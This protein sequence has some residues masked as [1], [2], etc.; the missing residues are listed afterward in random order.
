MYIEEINSTNSYLKQWMQT[1]ALP[2][3]LSHEVLPH[4]RAGYQTAGRGQQGN[5]WESERDMNLTCSML[6]RN[7]GLG[8]DE[9]WLISMMVSVAVCEVIDGYLSAK[10][11][12]QLTIKWPNDIYFG[13]YKLAGILIEHSLMG[14][15]IEYSIVGVGLNVNQKQFVS[16][17][18]PI[19]LSQ[20]T[21]KT[22][23]LQTVMD[24]M[25]AVT[26][27]KIGELRNT[28]ILR[29][30]YLSRLYRRE[31]F[32]PFVEREVSVAPTMNETKRVIDSFDAEIKTIT[33]QGQLVLLLRS[34][35]ERTYHFKQI[36]YVIE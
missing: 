15:Q 28:T 33:P 23:D 20:I 30:E 5:G 13:D 10:E 12:Q 11:R 16:A 32:H 4:I 7:T 17:P 34:G 36:R 18:N 29:Q 27:T 21:G 9:Q 2:K 6:I 3:P 31:G 35:E 22:L 8:A 25:V 1:G 14:K 26:Y 19:S 24:S